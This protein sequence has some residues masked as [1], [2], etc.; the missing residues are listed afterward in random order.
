MKYANFETLKSNIDFSKVY[1]AKQ[2]YANKLLVVY[3]LEN[4]T[5]TN[6]VGVSVS[7]KVG[8]S[9]V[10]HRLARLIRESFRLHS[11]EVLKGFDIVIVARAGLKGKNYFETESALLHLLK[12]HKLIK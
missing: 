7:K 5:D 8:N 2:S 11:H 12:M 3:I 4:G 10:R 1:E 9:I 6:R